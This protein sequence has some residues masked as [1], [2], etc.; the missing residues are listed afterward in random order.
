MMLFNIKVDLM[1]D[2]TDQRFRLND[3]DRDDWAL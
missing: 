1:V 3:L 2:L